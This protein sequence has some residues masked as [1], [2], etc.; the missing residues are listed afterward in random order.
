MREHED[1]HEKECPHAVLAA[2]HA[3]EY[4]GIGLDGT[5]EA[6]LGSRDTK[7]QRPAGRQK[8][9]YKKEQEKHTCHNIARHGPG[10][11]DVAEKDFK[12]TDKD[13]YDSVGQNES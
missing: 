12:K 13:D 3:V 1:E 4:A 6:R 10:M 8:Y 7:M 5:V 11:G 9:V 2:H